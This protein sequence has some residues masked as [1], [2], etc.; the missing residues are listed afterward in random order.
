MITDVGKEIISKYLLGQ[1][2]AY[3]THISIGCGAV[4]LDANDSP[5][6]PTTLAEKTRMDFEMTRVPIT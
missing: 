3:A 5:P 2:P 1:T 6:S 4:P